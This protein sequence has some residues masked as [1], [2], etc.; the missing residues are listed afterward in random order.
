MSRGPSAHPLEGDGL[1]SIAR[2]AG[3]AAAEHRRDELLTLRLGAGGYRLDMRLDLRIPGAI[4][5]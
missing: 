5:H 2:P 3:P 4:G 1:G